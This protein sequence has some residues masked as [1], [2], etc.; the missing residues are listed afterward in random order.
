MIPRS[1]QHRKEELRGAETAP[2]NDSRLKRPIVILAISVLVLVGLRLLP[3]LSQVLL[4]IFGGAIFAVLLD[5]VS[6]LACQRARVPRWLALTVF[7][8]FIL[9][10]LGAIGWLMGDRISGQFNQMTQR[11]TQGY[12]EAQSYLQSNEWTR[13]LTPGG[14][15]AL[16]NGIGSELWSR[17]GGVFSTTI[18]AVAN[19]FILM[20]IAVYLGATPDLY[21]RNTLLLVPPARRDRYAEVFSA[22]GSTLRWWFVGRFS[23]MA[24]T[25]AL[26]GIG[27]WLAGIPMALSL[28]LIAGVLSFVPFVGPIVAAI[29]GILVAW[30]Q[31]P[32]K[33][34]WALGVYIVVQLLES[35]VITPVI[36]RRA[37]QVPPTLL[38]G[39]QLLLGSLF[40]FWGVL[41]ATPLIV[42]VMV[43]VQHLYLKDVLHDES[44][45]P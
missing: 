28:G 5:G 24:V 20:V 12:Q 31:S 19:V 1:P 2:Q 44:A 8:L 30:V 7:I 18:G 4:V 16:M 32:T 17:M 43:I 27:L 40:G 13:R 22:L 42:V 45:G 41:W 26:T 11:V 33:A 14:D 21:L 39:G 3:T 38:I 34:A 35:N 10:S 15:G 23:S 29:P 25:G 6:T 37:V 36:Q 9:G